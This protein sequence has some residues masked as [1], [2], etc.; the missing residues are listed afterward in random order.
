MRM[1]MRVMVVVEV[2]AGI[3]VDFKVID[4]RERSITLFRIRARIRIFIYIRTYVSKIL[5]Y[6]E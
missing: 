5:S 2:S 3:S 1:W 6:A 4:C